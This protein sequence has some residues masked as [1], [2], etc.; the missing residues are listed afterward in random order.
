MPRVRV[1]FLGKTFGRLTI[2][3][4]D[5]LE[6]CGAR[7]VIVKCKCGNVKRVR[8]DRLKSGVTKS[9]GC[10]QKELLSKQQKTHGLTKHPLYNIRV[11]IIRRCYNPATDSFDNYGGRGIQVCDEWLN[12]F[13]AFYDWAMANGWKK[14][15]QVDRHPDNNGNYE[16]SNCRITTAKK[17]SRNKTNNILFEYNGE[18]RVLGEWCEI[19]NRSFHKVRQ[20]IYA[21]WSF[22][23]AM[24]LI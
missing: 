17:N 13:Q 3:I 1:G 20:R 7:T 9:C 15:L 2:I 12:D 22:E 23:N 4:D 16:P 11:N 21:G 18:K 8:L 24:E 5:F 19:F 10:L 14:G 6:I